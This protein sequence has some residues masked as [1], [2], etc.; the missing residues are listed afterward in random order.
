MSRYVDD[1]RLKE[2]ENLLVS[3]VWDRLEGEWA[4][5]Q[6]QYKVNIGLGYDVTEQLKLLVQEDARAWTRFLVRKSE[7]MAT[8][9]DVH[10]DGT[11]PEPGC[12]I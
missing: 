8:N 4:L 6:E 10:G 7:V 2:D 9:P 5:H 11:A 12:G 3:K 1:P